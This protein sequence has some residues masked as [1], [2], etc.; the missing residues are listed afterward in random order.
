M[1]KGYIK[2]GCDRWG[3]FVSIQLEGCCENKFYGYK[4][5]DVV[6]AYCNYHG[7]NKNNVSWVI[8]EEN[9]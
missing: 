6:E 1:T 4:K 5:E 3:Y 7:C 2:T 9:V 8:S